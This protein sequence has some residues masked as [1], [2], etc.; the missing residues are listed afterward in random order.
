MYMQFFA[1]IW[2][3]NT[4]SNNDFSSPIVGI[5]CL[6]C[7]QSQFSTKVLNINCVDGKIS[8]FAVVYVPLNFS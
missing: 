7:F 8:S 4:C 5:R 6:Q 3:I 1:V 2:L